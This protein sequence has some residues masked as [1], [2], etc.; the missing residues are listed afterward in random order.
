MRA[1]LKKLHSLDFD[2]ETYYPED[3]KNFQITLEAEIGVEGVSGADRFEFIIMAGCGAFLGDPERR[4]VFGKNRLIVKEYNLKVIY[5]T[6][7]KLCERTFGD[8]WEVIAT[9]IA[10]FGKWEFDGYTF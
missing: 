8:S 3:D 4:S 6:I 5:R 9:Q 1:E 7:Q 10:K 2:L